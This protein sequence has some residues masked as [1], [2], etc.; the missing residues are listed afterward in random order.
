MCH[1]RKVHNLLHVALA[2]HG[3]A[4]LAAGHHVGMVAEDVQG[5]GGY[6]TGGN[7]EHAGQLLGRDLVHVGDHQQQTL[8]S[9]VRGGQSAGA[10]RTVYRAGRTGFGL[11][12]HHLDRGAEDVFLS[13]GAP[14]VNKVGHGRGRSDGVDGG[15]LGKR[16][17]YMRRGVVAIHGFHF[18]SHL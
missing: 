5:V 14:L 13:I 1:G 8:G 16:I 2:Q 7:M 10:Q 9:G 3:K 4:G 12:L 11:H 17:A 6:G 15:Y 18:S